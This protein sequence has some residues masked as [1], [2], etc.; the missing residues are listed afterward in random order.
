MHLES[1]VPSGTVVQVPTEPLR[2]Q[3]WQASPHALSQQT[4]DEQYCFPSFLD[5]WHS[6]A[7][8]QEAPGGLR[9]HDPFMHEL[10][11]EH[12]LSCEQTE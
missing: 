12:W 11:A 6:A 9:P 1:A 2:L 7:A 8:L 3:A 10:L 4:P 5:V